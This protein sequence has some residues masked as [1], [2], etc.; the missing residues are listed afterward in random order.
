MLVFDSHFIGLRLVNE[1]ELKKVTSDSKVFYSRVSGSSLDNYT[2]DHTVGS[3]T[4]DPKDSLCLFTKRGQ[5]PESIT[6]DIKQL[7]AD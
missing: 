3:H 4:L 2:I 6:H 7:L 5:D 1:T